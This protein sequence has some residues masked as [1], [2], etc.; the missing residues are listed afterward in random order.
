[1]ALD[2][3]IAKNTKEAQS[4]SCSASFELNA[5]EFIFHRTDLP[6]EQFPLFRRMEDYYKDATYG[7]EELQSLIK[8]LNELR[9]LFCNNEQTAKQLEHL[10][11]ACKKA[12]AE[13]SS[14]WVYCD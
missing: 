6:R 3:H 7:L 12:Q 1:M 4:I 9:V 13:H 11:I 5:H 14:I 8:E 2:F 10:L